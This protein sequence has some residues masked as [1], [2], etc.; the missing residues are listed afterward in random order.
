M[1]EWVSGKW[2]K[3]VEWCMDGYV[4]KVFK[5]VFVVVLVV[6]VVKVIEMWK[7]VECGNGSGFVV[8][9]LCCWGE[10]R[11]VENNYYFFLDLEN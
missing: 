1:K 7:G 3:G 9:Y 11:D 2:I 5:W 4:D 6:V 8:E 10:N